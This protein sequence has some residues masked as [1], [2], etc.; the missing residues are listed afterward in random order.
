MKKHKIAYTLSVAA[1][2]LGSGVFAPMAFADDEVCVASNLSELKACL[3]SDAVSV[4]TTDTIVVAGEG[5][6]ETLVV[7]KTIDGASGKNVFSIEDG[8]SLTLRGSGTINAGRYGAT[9]DGAEL[10]I[11]G[12]IIN[13]TNSGCYG[14]YARDNGRV[15]MQSGQV[16][17]D[18]AAFAGNNT[19]GDMNFYING[20][21]LHSERYPAIYMPG[22]VDLQVRGGTLDGGIVARMGQIEIEGGTINQQAT[23]VEGDGLDVNYGG[24]PSIA[25]EAITLVAGSYKSANAEHGNDMN[26]IIRGEDTRINGDIVLYDLGNTAD[27]YAQN[28][29]IKIEDGYLTGFETKFTEEEIGFALRAG[30][31]AGLNNA[32]E[33]INIEISGGRYVTEPAREDLVPGFEA[34]QDKETGTWTIYPEKVDWGPEGRWFIEDGGE[35]EGHLSV[36]VEFGKET[37]AD[38]NATLSAVE[39]STDGLTLNE[40]E[41][42]ELIGAFEI[43]MLDRNGGRIEIKDNELLVY[44]DLDEESHAMLSAYDKLFAVYFENGEEIER[45]EVYLSNADEEGYW[46]SFETTHLSTYAIVGVNEEETV[47]S[48]DAVAVATPDT[49]AMTMEGGSAASVAIVTVVLVGV[50]VTIMSLFTVLKRR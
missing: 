7:N 40:E 47:E 4:T 20:G 17:A 39:R 30:Y 36:A 49:G 28:V 11:D 45:H 37:I 9:A 24:M 42:G 3:E 16:N 33:R 25:D 8:A 6:T 34:E 38:R 46:L 19:T 50:A 18:Y 31:T 44:F 12:P 22:Q 35:S 15:F 21:L 13:A 41:G 1:L 27:G 43:D 5:T 26:V 2:T 48:T 32:A 23:P 14:V 10:I 29:D